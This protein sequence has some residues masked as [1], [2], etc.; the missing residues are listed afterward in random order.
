MAKSFLIPVDLLKN[1]IRN[2]RVHNLA[3]APSGP[4]TG[5]IYYDTVANKLY[6]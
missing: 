3:L 5:Q 2:V 1:E 4:V 6:Y